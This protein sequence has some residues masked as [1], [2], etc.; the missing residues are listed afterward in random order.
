[1]PFARL[2][3]GLKEILDYRSE[4]EA[5]RDDLPYEIDGLVVKINSIEL[6]RRLGEIARSPR[7]AVAYKF[8]PRQATT[9]I[10]DIQPQ[11]GR[12]GTLT[13]VASLEPVPIGGVTVKSASLHNMD[14][15]ERKDIRIGD[16]VWS[17]GPAT[18]SL[19]GTSF[20]GKGN[21]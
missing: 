15:I 21:G 16:T 14:E 17:S 20:N 13:P 7:W 3:H 11:V 4:M 12:T 1:M 5:R 10:L 8:K 2:C 9:R 6:Q 18:Y 19:R